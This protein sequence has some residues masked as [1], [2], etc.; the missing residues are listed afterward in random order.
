MTL[1]TLDWVS[2]GGYFLAV[3]AV[4]MWFGKFT[5][6]TKDFFFGGQR[7]AWWLVG[8]SCVATLVGSY[9]F[10]QYAEIG[11]NFGFGASTAYTNEWF[12]LPLFLLV[13]LPIVYY[14]RIQSIPEYFARRFDHRTRMLVL[15]LLLVYL[16]V[17]VGINLWTIGVALNGLFGWNVML[18]AAIMAVVSGLYLHA[19]GQTSVLMTDLL[20][21][22]LLLAIGLGVFLLGIAHV[23]GAETF[24]SGLPPEH[25][26]PFPPFTRDPS[27]HAVGNFWG[28]TI[29][30]TFAFYFINQGVLMRFLSA[31]S[32]RDARRAMLFV[33]LILMPLAAVAVCGAG[34]V[35]RAMVTHGDLPADTNSKDIFVEVAR[36]VCSPG[37]FGLVIAAMIAA[38]M[39]TLDTLLN[40]VSAIAVNDVWKPLK[41]GQPDAYYLKAARHVTIGATVL[42]IFLTPIFDQFTTIYQALTHFTSM[43]T[44]PLITVIVLGALWKRFNARAAFWTLLLG[45]LGIL[46]SM[47]FPVLVKPFAHGDDPAEGYSYMRGLYGLVLCLALAA[48]FTWFGPKDESEP[49]D[50]LLVTTIEAGARIF[51]GGVPQFPQQTKTVVLDVQ[52][53]PTAENPRLPQSAM[54][55]MNIHEGDV[56]YISDARR[57]LGGFR[58]F[59]ATAGPAAESDDHIHLTANALEDGNLMD[60]R[61]VRV[62]KI[63]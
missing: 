29:V 24:W 30:G 11:Y 62:E 44:P 17:Y 34:W 31:K 5:K 53:D 14:S 58:A 18:S 39:S 8:V 42:G 36:L 33:V 59:H 4:G 38:L 46:L 63:M 22:F 37:I 55:Q 57:W 40:A 51:K 20:Q 60:N 25:R 12:V 43:I 10:I 21:G 3:V 52:T 6:T 28:D 35:G 50:G 45:S 19:G 26:L 56:I 16:E 27:F 61:K 47:F 15:L 7:F 32:V 1:H 23:G 9:S 48:A 54:T 41:P 2:L 49:P 13:W